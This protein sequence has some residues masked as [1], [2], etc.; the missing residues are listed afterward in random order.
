VPSPEAPPASVVPYR[1][2]LLS[3]ITAACGFKPAGATNE[4]SVETLGAY[5][6]NPAQR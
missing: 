1:L 2:P 6:D 3:V 4:P 5:P